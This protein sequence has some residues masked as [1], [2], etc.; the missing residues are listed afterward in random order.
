MNE[1]YRCIFTGHSLGGAVATLL[2]VRVLFHEKIKE[3]SEFTKNVLCVGFGTPAVGTSKFSK[4]VEDLYKE[5]FHFYINKSD[6]VVLQTWLSSRIYVQFGK[7]NFI[8]DDGTVDVTDTYKRREQ[9]VIGHPEHHYSAHYVD[10]IIKMLEKRDK[11]N[12]FADDDKI[13]GVFNELFLPIKQIKK[14]KIGNSCDLVKGCPTFFNKYSVMVEVKKKIFE[15]QLIIVNIC[16]ENS[17]FIY[18]A[19][20]KLEGTSSEYAD[21]KVKRL[22]NNTIELNFEVPKSINLEKAK[23]TLILQT[24]FEVASLPIEL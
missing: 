13:I 12:I 5:N 7:F 22:N 3:K 14:I 24:H 18:K 17:E 9:E 23:G 1:G 8:H 19:I 2:A 21:L 15:K 6:I 10:N 16:C 4:H 20:L 11:E